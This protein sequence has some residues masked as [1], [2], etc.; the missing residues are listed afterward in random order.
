MN[1]RA[2][3]IEHEKEGDIDILH[4]EGS[5]DAYSFPQLEVV[6][7]ELQE[8]ERSRVIL[9]CT[10]LEY[11]SSVG[12]GA[13]IGFARRARENNGDLKLINLSKRIFNIIEMLGFHKILATLPGKAEAIE[14]F[15]H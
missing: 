1:M 10:K 4:L 9:D 7:Q 2:C 8:N 5:L 15:T 11:I 3:N 6:L 12:L 13:L 14:S